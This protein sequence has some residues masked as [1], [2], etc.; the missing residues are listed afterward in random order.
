MQKTAL[1]TNRDVFQADLAEKQQLIRVA[2]GLAPAE[3]VL[4]NAVYL[5]VF[6]NEWLTGDIAV[7]GNRIAG[8]GSYSGKREIDLAGK[9]LSPG[10]ID[11]HIHLES[12]LVS[13]AEFARAVLRA[14]TTAVVTDPHEIANVMGKDGIQYMLEA[15]ENL[16]IDVFFMLPS[17][18]PATPQDESGARLSFADIEAFYQNPRV[19]GLAEMMDYP[20]V[21]NANAEPL[22]KILAARQH[23]HPVDGHAPLL[24]GQAL[25]A[26]VAAGIHSDHECSNPDEALEKLRCGH[27]IMIREGTA[28]KNLDALLPLLCEQYA[29]RCLFATDDKHPED[30]LLTGHIDGMVRRAVHAGVDPVFALKAASFNAAQ[31]FGLQDKGAIAPGYFAD[32]V[33]FDN[34]TDFTVQQ[35]YK[36]GTLMFDSGKVCDF[37]DPPVS[38]ALRQRAL[39]TFHLP[40]VTPASFQTNQPLPVL[41]IIKNQLM[42]EKCGTADKIDIKK[43]ILKIAVV[44]RHHNTGH[45]GIGYIHGYGLTAGAVA[46]SIAHDA[47]NI[48]AVG[49]SDEELSAAVNQIIQNKGG[50]CVVK[51]TQVLSE[52]P[53]PVAGLMSDKPL[54][55]VNEQLETAKKAASALGVPE[56]IDPFMTLS[57]VSLPVIPKLRLTTKGMFDVQT[58]SYL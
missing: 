5:N 14:G 7:Q 54:S 22:L 35:V 31:Y 50:M 17:C 45:I 15:T 25:N 56:G 19:R 51:G 52:V 44:E 40:P 57:F 53:L 36:N 26:Y 21:A 33:V 24:S 1:G 12:S 48:I 9:I 28:A 8:V 38:E 11:A 10:L 34:L 55:T 13:P 43:D 49:C 29:S 3:L 30:L 20:G 16:P 6:S 23:G 27:F 42:T 2:M 39:D 58:Q 41:Q 32:L 46:T 47:H 4:K 18:V 37:A